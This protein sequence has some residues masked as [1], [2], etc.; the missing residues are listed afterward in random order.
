MSEK[1]QGESWQKL[2]ARKLLQGNPN[3]S[4]SNE[5]KDEVNKTTQHMK[6]IKEVK[7][8]AE[9][10]SG[11][12]QLRK[13]A[14]ESEKARLKSEAELAQE[15]QNQLQ[16]QIRSMQTEITKLFDQKGPNPEVA[17]LMQELE[18]SKNELIQTRFNYLDNQIK[19]L[20]NM[21]AAGA[22]QTDLDQ[23]I[24]QIKAAATELGL[25]P[26]SGTTMS[27][28]LQVQ[29]KQMDIN[30]QLQM[31]QMKDERDRRDKEWQLTVRKWD[32]E[33]EQRE[34]E[35]AS[36]VAVE[37]EKMEIVG[38]FV[39]KIGV[40]F[41]QASTAAGQETTA[42]KVASQAIEAGEGDFGEINCPT[43]GCRGTIAVAKDAVKAVCPSCS[44]VYDI[45]RIAKEPKVEPEVES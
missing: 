43:P 20:S 3:S 34:R 4:V 23:Q 19:E 36:K 17:R 6:A 21:K 11:A 41:A 42:G 37:R 24:K 5:D 2:V 32:E 16:E 45:Q 1:L 31:E 40:T 13:Q 22:S 35:L 28:E 33:K 12:G 30:L 10:L 44:T 8:V 39:K 15:R 25:Q 27:P 18:N 9:E 38:D 29:I 14:A 7:D 26:P